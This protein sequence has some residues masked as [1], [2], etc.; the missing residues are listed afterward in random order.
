MTRKPR[1]ST[2]RSASRAEA[3]QKAP[4]SLF[5]AL[6]AFAAFIAYFGSLAYALTAA[7]SQVWGALLLVPVLV[8]ITIPLC[9]AAGRHQNDPRLPRLLVVGLVLK[10]AGACLRYAVAF[11]VYSGEADSKA[12]DRSAASWQPTSE[13]DTSTSA[14]VRSATPTSSK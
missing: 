3:G 11:Q 6:F 4:P 10:M 5:V 7:S 9:K 8:V 13:P 14:T 12:Y 2:S 1:P